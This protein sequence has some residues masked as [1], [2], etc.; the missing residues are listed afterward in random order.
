MIAN[1][2][3]VVL[4]ATLP[5]LVALVVPS[6]PTLVC[7]VSVPPAVPGIVTVI[8]QVI[9]PAA[10]TLAA[11]PPALYVHTPLA[12]TAAPAGKPAANV[13]VGFVAAVLA[14]TLVHTT[15]PLNT[16]PGP[17]VAGKPVIATLMSEIVGAFTVTCRVAV[18]Q[19]GGATAG[20][21]QIV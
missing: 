15:L 1:G 5:S 9:V 13:H 10:G 8:G 2:A 16:A 6:T 7:V 4:L 18:S 12:T 14:A 21:L 3:L 19:A 17:A 11:E 20:L